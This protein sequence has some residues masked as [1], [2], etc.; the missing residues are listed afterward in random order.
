MRKVL[1][2]MLALFALSAT[3]V[4]FAEDLPEIPADDST[5]QLPPLV[6][7]ADAS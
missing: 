2:A 7:P 4:A 5:P 1:L 6:D 3:P